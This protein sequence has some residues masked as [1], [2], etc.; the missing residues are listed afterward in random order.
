MPAESRPDDQK[1]PI[2]RSHVNPNAKAPGTRVKTI[3]RSLILEAV[4]W[5]PRTNGG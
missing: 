4:L 3:G 1:I 2:D 5:E